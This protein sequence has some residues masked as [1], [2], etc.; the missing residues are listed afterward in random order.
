[1]AQAMA[2]VQPGED[3]AWVVHAEVHTG[4]PDRED[5]NDRAGP[6]RRAWPAT[7]L[8]SSP[9]GPR[10]KWRWSWWSGRALLLQ[11]HARR[12]QVRWLESS[13]PAATDSRDT[14]PWLSRGGE[15][16]LEVRERLAA[17][18]ATLG[19][20]CRVQGCGTASSEG[21]QGVGRFPPLWMLRRSSPVS[22][23]ERL[24]PAAGRALVRAAG[25][26]AGRGHR[27]GRP[28]GVCG[29]RAAWCGRMVL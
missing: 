15:D 28:C 1:M 16:H 6:Q 7:P 25:A 26:W 4:D 22:S 21:R 2:S 29:R 9:S 19:G 13:S 23:R 24:T 14:E 5:Q 17:V 27:V 20:G 3:V 11:S 18:L 8:I 12:R 10:A